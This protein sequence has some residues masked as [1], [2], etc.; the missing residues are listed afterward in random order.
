M[1][2]LKLQD[3]KLSNGI[4]FLELLTAVE[5]QVVNWSLV[6]RGDSG[7]LCKIQTETVLYLFLL[8]SG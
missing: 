3:K 1:V 2:F 8:L 6:T 5:P 4:F 7:K